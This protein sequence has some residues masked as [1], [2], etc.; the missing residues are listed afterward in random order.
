[1]GKRGSYPPA[2]ARRNNF[3][4]AHQANNATTETRG[5][6]GLSLSK[7]SHNVEWRSTGPQLSRIG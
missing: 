4:P 6:P 2:A 3:A 5:V 1:M 7:P